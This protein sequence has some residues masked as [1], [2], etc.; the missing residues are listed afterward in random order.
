[1]AGFSVS[2]V[3]GYLA[4]GGPRGRGIPARVAAAIDRR[5]AAAERSIGWVQLA[6]V[7]FFGALYLLAPRAEG[8]V[9]ISI[10][11]TVLSVY[12]AFT[13][14][15]LALS[16]RITL[17]GWLLVLSILVDVGILCALILSFPIQYAQPA[18][19]SLKAPTMIYLFIF[20]SLRALRFDPRFVLIAG[21]AA[22]LGWGLIVLRAL[23]SD[24]GQMRIT[25]N[26]VEY[27]TSNTILIGA[28]IDKLVTLLGVTFI[29]SFALYRA[30]D[31]FFDAMQARAEAEDLKKFFAPEVARSITGSEA[32]PA[33]GHS[34]QREAAMLFVDVRS[35][36]DTA[37][38]MEPGD[39][40]AVLARYQE[41]AVEAIQRH[42]GQ[43]D[44]FLGDG[45]LATFG[46]LRDSPAHAA[47]ALRAG[48]AVMAALD[49]VQGDMAA[50]GWPGA[51]RTGA[52]V[53]AGLVTVGVVG[54]A[55]R[56]E[57]TVIG[58]AVNRAAKLEAANKVL[59]TR[60]LTDLATLR[61]AVAQGYAG[62]QGDAGAAP[63]VRR[64]A[65]AGLGEA[66]DVVVVA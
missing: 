31:V 34:E 49:G 2:S 32:L 8:A 53:A 56:L 35:F 10:V 38:R 60:M 54:A 41:V 24:M 42:G 13:L 3:L 55:G 62:A 19:F 51:F 40:M 12:F 43:I 64:V 39:V 46:A 27:L 25:R 14:F 30:R 9:G 4:G 66:V 5:E 1:M 17:P 23:T 37:A 29:L 48:C 52:A 57:F 21:L 65:V 44:K 58:N 20:I 63:E 6:F 50:R 33:A 28:E 61:A 59:G 26:Y 18:A 7:V 36:S 16:Y 45:I 47:D 15:R 11:P 22:T